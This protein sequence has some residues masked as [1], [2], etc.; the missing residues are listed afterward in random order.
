MNKWNWPQ[1]LSTPS[2]CSCVCVDSENGDEGLPEKSTSTYFVLKFARICPDFI[3]C[4][5]DLVQGGD[6]QIIKSH[7]KVLPGRF[8]GLLKSPRKVQK[9]I[10]KRTPRA[11]GD[12]PG[13]SFSY[14]LQEN[15]PTREG[16]GEGLRRRPPL[17]VHFLSKNIEKE[18]PGLSR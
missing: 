12:D 3:L 2:V 7:A 11:D 18:L 4:G 5:W 16:G 17:W 14:F 10:S 9:K 1:E 15:E 8:S 13:S 6:R